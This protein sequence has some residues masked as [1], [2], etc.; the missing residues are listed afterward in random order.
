MGGLC[1]IGI[2]HN[3]KKMCFLTKLILR[4][5]DTFCRTIRM[6]EYPTKQRCHNG[7]INSLVLVCMADM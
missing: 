4:Q 1:G 7:P 3:I 2:W 6:D 5:I